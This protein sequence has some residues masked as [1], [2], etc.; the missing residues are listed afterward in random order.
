MAAWSGAQLPLPAA[1]GAVG[2]PG[3]SRAKRLAIGCG[4]GR[5][6]T[7]RIHVRTDTAA[8]DA[9]LPPPPDTATRCRMIDSA[10]TAT[11]AA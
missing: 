1:L 2:R 9:R 3:L 4:P 5:A 6:L 8:I 7:D 10:S 11:K